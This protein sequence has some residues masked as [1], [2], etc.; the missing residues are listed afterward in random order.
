M[1]QW[2]LYV[3]V[4]LSLIILHGAVWAEEGTDQQ[5]ELAKK[6]SNPVAYQRAVAKQLGLRH[7]DSKCDA[8]YP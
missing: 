8:L 1:K 4:V 3:C 2:L 6:L 5:A 7:R